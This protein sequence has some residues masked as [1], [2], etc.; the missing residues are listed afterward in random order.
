MRAA[1]RGQVVGRPS[2]AV[3]FEEQRARGDI[4]AGVGIREMTACSSKEGEVYADKVQAEGNELGFES[5]KIQYSY[6]STG[7]TCDPPPPRRISQA[8]GKSAGVFLVLA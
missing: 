4:A 3:W 6:F 2:A 7:K 8:E 5:K 1:W